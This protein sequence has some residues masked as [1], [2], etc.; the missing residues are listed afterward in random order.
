MDGRQN[1]LLTPKTELNLLSSLRRCGSCVRACDCASS[2]NDELYA[3]DSSSCAR[4]GLDL[5]A[6]L[7]IACVDATSTVHA[8]VVPV[9]PTV[10]RSLSSCRHQNPDK[11]IIALLPRRL[12]DAAAYAWTDSVYIGVPRWTRIWI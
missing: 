7:R 4:Y 11:K 3:P 2:R 6:G 5:I 10:V 9:V 12:I 1:G 8:T